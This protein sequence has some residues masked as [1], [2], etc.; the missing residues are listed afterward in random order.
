MKR[1]S[2]RRFLA[3]TAG[4]TAAA[5]LALAC[6][7]GQEAIPTGGEAAAV[8]RRGGVWKGMVN[9]DVDTFDPIGARTFRTHVIAS[10]VY[11]KLFRFAP[12]RG[13]PADGTVEGDLVERWEVVDG[14][15][16]VLHLR[17]SA[18]W[19]SREPTAGR[20]VTSADVVQSWKAWAERGVYRGDLV[21]A[22][23]PQA[24]VET[25]EAPDDYTVI[26]KTA[27]PDADLVPLLAFA[28]NFWVVPSEGLAGRFNL[29]T[30]VRGAGPWL[31]ESYQPGVRFMFR[32]NPD[33]HGGPEVP[34][35][36][37]VE[38]PIITDASQAEAQFRAGNVWA[39]VG[40][41][42]N[43]GFAVVSPTNVPV[44]MRELPG[45]VVRLGTPSPNGPTFSFGM[46]GDSPFRDVRVRRAFSML[47][48]RDALFEAFADLR[49]LKD[50]GVQVR[51]YKSTPLGAGWG[52]FW[53]NPDDAAF[54]PANRY[55]RYDPREAEA[56]L[57]AAGFPKDKE[58]VLTTLSGP[59]YGTNWKQIGEAAA[60]M[61]QRAGLR[62]RLNPVDYTSVW[63][64]RYLRAQSNFE[65]IA[66]YP[67]GARATPAQ[68]LGVF[69]SSWGANNQV[70][71]NYP[72]LDAMI[73]SL[74]KEF[75]RDQAIKLAH[76]IQRFMVENMVAIPQYGSIETPYL[77]WQ[78][79]H[80]PG[81]IF[82]WPGDTPYD[83]GVEGLPY[84]WT[85]R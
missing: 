21:R 40:G 3:L 84:W 17:R 47:L 81:E 54:G 82:L 63:V 29:N 78:H 19:D 36:D 33:W 25:V 26:V 52:D 42:A 62:V 66:M 69:F 30:D 14:T 16:L 65:G 70:G 22:A 39:P 12:G 58:I 53:L 4:S 8:P 55:L 76:D 71:R 72:E 38:V 18:R 9:F 60:S 68:W 44:L 83:V 51:A 6:R 41:S 45:T 73:T 1:Y 85:E 43:A 35:L 34:L 59:E 7:G 20:P 28:F 24:S 46:A 2:R 49:A 15:T 75:R 23:N 27:Y 48:D 37:G 31:L 74:R 56:L 50:A 64:P 11:P 67:N 77:L 32:R 57:S 80:G 5:A 79:T 13:K 61:W 10:F